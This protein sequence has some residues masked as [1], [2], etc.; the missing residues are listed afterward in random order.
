MA[1]YTLASKVRVLSMQQNGLCRSYNMLHTWI[2]ISG[3]FM[4][5]RHFNV[6]AGQVELILTM[7]S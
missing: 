3:A 2:I 6:V 4:C 5:K 1:E 7:T